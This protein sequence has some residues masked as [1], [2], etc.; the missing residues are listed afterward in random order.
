M[1]GMYGFDH[2]KF[3]ALAITWIACQLP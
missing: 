3:L 1:V 2:E